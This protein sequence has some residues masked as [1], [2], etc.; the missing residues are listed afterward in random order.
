[1]ADESGSLGREGFHEILE[2]GRREV[3][4]RRR[5]KPGGERAAGLALRKVKNE[6]GV[7]RREGSQAGPELVGSEVSAS[8]DREKLMP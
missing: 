8:H 6:G 5:E 3:V 2:L 4:R 7:G 1:M